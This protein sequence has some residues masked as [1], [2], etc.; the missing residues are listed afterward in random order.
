MARERIA[1]MLPLYRENPEKLRKCL[2]ALVSQKGADYSVFVVLDRNADSASVS[3]AEGFSRKLRIV[4]TK[5]K[6]VSELRNYCLSLPE[7]FDYFAFTDPDCVPGK[8]WLNSLK[9]GLPEGFS[10]IGGSDPFE[11]I[12]GLFNEFMRGDIESRLGKRGETYWLDTNNLFVRSRDFRLVGG[13]NENLSRGTDTFISE[14][15][16]RAGKRLF[17]DPKIKVT[18]L[19][20]Y[21]FQK[22]LSECLR[23]GKSHAELFLSGI[24][25]SKTVMSHPGKFY[26]LQPAVAGV[27]LLALPVFPKVSFA[28]A[29]LLFAMGL[30]KSLRQS[31]QN[32]MVFSLIF[33]IRPFLWFFGGISGALSHFFRKIRSRKGRT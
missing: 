26:L 7:K 20:D 1:V 11:S 6:T 3:V 18:H 4:R 12:P 10:A 14:N 22:F 28:S 33:S 32:K 17:F 29:S 30:L 27:S 15:L 16:V 23:Y 2:S 25:F 13:F 31:S 8:N 19:K 9:S 24:R 5:G 21:S